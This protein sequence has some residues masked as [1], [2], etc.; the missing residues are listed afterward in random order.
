MGKGR[1]EAFSDGVLAIIITVMVLELKVPHG[2]DF[3]ALNPLLPVFLSYVLSFVYLAIYWNNHHH[4][5]HTTQRVTGAILWANLHL[6]FWLSLFPFVTGWMGE[7]HFACAP[8]VLYGFVLLMAAVAYYLLQHAIIA[9]QGIDSLL[10]RAVGRDLKGKLS[11]VL[12]GTAIL[13]AFFEPWISHGI[14]VFV[15]LMWL[16]PDRRIERILGENKT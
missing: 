9:S 3:S 7:D 10:A 6:L 2:A 14:Y 4:M 1:L 15:A 8:V 11:P 13:S 12:Y 5:L 16:V